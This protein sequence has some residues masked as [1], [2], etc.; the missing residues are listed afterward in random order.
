[1]MITPK[2]VTEALQAGGRLLKRSANGQQRVL[3]YDKIGG[4]SYSR[5]FKGLSTEDIVAFPER[6]RISSVE[7]GANNVITKK[8]FDSYI[9]HSYPSTKFSDHFTKTS[10]DYAEGTI[11]TAIRNGC[12]SFYSPDLKSLSGEHPDILRPEKTTTV[13][14]L[15]KNLTSFFDKL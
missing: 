3:M 9:D 2:T 14:M 1:M 11:T 10:R 12:K 6:I 5:I 4:R 15:L 7:R 13:P 8:Q